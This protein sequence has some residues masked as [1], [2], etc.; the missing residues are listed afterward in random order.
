MLPDFNKDCKSPAVCKVM[1]GALAAEA[2]AGVAE[3]IVNGIKN[4]KDFCLNPAQAAGNAAANFG[5]NFLN[6]MGGAGDIIFGLA[7]YRSPL[8]KMKDQ[9]TQVQQEY[10]NSFDSFTQTFASIQAS[11]D[12]EVVGTMQAINKTDNAIAVYYKDMLEEE[13]QLNTLRIVFLFIIL[14]IIY[15]YLTFE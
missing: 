9:I 13:I 3:G 11:F 4:E 1:A 8:D 15:I 12:E 14:M 6:I 2:V 10:R 5:K 7:G